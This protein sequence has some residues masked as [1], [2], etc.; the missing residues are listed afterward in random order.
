[1]IIERGRQGCVWGEYRGAARTAVPADN[2]PA[3]E[4]LIVRRCGRKKVK[5]RKT[6][7]L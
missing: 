6:N 1:M 3:E 7:S 5:E 2:D 4:A